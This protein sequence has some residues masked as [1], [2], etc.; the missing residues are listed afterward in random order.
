MP[1]EENPKNENFQYIVRVANR[2]LNGE[3]SV[4]MAL[5]DLKGIGVRLAQLISAKLSLPRDKKI[6][7]L[8]EEQIEKLR[9]Y[10][11]S[12]SY[13]GI[14]EWALNHRGEFVS[15][16][17]IN[18]VTN[19]L[20]A[21]IQDDI[22]LMKKIKSYKGVRHEKGKKVRGQRTRSNGRK[23]LTVGVQRKKE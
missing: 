9:E 18:L 8:S 13:E 12:K 15:G 20:E 10:V 21:Q 16:E 4:E 23:G 7:E 14:P 5:A 11:E 3:R 1:K 17:D 19:D 2:D 6:G 22:N